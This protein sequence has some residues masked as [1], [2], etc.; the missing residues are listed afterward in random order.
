MSADRACFNAA[1]TSQLG[2]GE[3]SAQR[4][5][6]RD[7]GQRHCTAHQLAGLSLRPGAPEGGA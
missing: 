4:G 6:E 1:T 7:E 3:A 2:A 5:G